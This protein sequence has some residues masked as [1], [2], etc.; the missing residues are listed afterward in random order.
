MIRDA[1]YDVD[2]TGEESTGYGGKPP[3]ALGKRE[4]QYD[5]DWTGEESTGYGGKPPR[6]LRERDAQYDVDWTGEESTGYG[7]KPPRARSLNEIIGRGMFSFPFP[8][9]KMLKDLN[10]DDCG[11]V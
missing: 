1:Q 4:A 7:G 11:G 8:V 5:V 3:R 6:A 9:L 10:A 2:W